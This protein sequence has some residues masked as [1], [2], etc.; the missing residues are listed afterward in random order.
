MFLS[1]LSGLNVKVNILLCATVF[2][3]PYSCKF[4]GSDKEFSVPNIDDISKIVL[5]KD[6]VP[7]TVGKSGN[8]WFT[9]GEPANDKATANLLR[10]VSDVDPEYVLP[11]SYENE[12]TTEKIVREGVE[13][14][15]YGEKKEIKRWTALYVAGLGTVGVISGKSTIYKLYI[16]GIEIDDLTAYMNN[17]PGFWR[18]NILFSLQPSDIKYIRVDNTDPTESFLLKIDPYPEIFDEKNRKLSIADTGVV[19][20]YL[21]YFMNVSFKRYL[22]ASDNFEYVSGSGPYKLTLGTDAGESTYEILFIESDKTG[23][24]GNPL[25]Y[26]RDRFCLTL[27]KGDTALVDWLNFDILLKQLSDFVDK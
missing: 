13:I 4:V 5:T 18:R 14:K 23:N 8:A 26:D 2:F 3:V 12:I 11:G 25:I 22:S 10:I 19:K 21:T 27:P 24:Y 6:S 17:D 16:P 7:L 20:R 1:N 9:E 15:I